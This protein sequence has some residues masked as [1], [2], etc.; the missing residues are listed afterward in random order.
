M[1]PYVIV[2]EEISREGNG[3]PENYYLCYFL[4]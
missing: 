3:L 1:S 4:L 2:Y